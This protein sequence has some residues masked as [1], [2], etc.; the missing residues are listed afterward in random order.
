MGRLSVGSRTTVRMNLEMF[1]PVIHKLQIYVFGSIEKQLRT[2]IYYK[3]IQSIV[4]LYFFWQPFC[5]L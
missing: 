2:L 1:F 4:S 3:S 5:F